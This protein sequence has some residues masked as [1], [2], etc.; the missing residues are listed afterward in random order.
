MIPSSHIQ[1]EF[2]IDVTLRDF[3]SASQSHLLLL[4][5]RKAIEDLS[6]SSGEMNHRS[7]ILTVTVMLWGG[8]SRGVWY[9]V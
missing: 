5:T 6:A 8:S 4:S 2:D 1:K 9:G 7:A 3:S